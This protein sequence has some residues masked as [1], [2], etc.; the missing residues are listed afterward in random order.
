[1]VRSRERFAWIYGKLAPVLLA[2]TDETVARMRLAAE[3]VARTI[4]RKVVNRPW[5]MPG[6]FQGRDAG[7]CGSVCSADA[8]VNYC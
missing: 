6:S 8:S 4:A 1:M 5:G 7:S 2:K 3:M